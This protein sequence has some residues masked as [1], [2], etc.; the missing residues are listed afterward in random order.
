M[1]VKAAEPKPMYLLLFEEPNYTS[2]LA[3]SGSSSARSNFS[4]LTILCREQLIPAVRRSG[5][6]NNL[7]KNA[8]GP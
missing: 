4:P 6:D 2:T 1:K 8:K 5:V 3:R 7:H